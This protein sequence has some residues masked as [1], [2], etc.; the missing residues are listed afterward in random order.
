MRPWWQKGEEEC[1][2]CP[3]RYATGAEHWCAG[4]DRPMCS[5]CVQGVGAGLPLCPA[6]RQGVF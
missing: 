1:G 4:C 5:G 6:C 3:G 2:F